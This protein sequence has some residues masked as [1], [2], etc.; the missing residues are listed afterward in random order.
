MRHQRK[1][2]G[3]ENKDAGQQENGPENQPQEVITAHDGPR[4][5][6]RTKIPRSQTSRQPAPNSASGSAS[7]LVFVARNTLFS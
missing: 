7:I 5:N 4:F 1:N 3:H 6:L 2:P